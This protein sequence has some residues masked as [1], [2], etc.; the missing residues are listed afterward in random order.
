MRN[1]M[2]IADDDIGYRDQLSEL[3][4]DKFDI[5]TV[6]NGRE[7]M[8]YLVDHHKEIAIILVD[9]HM[10]IIDGRALLK[11]LKLKGVI[12]RIPVIMMT[13]DRDEAL[14]A[15]SFE[16]GATDMIY[17][18]FVPQV[19]A[20]R[21]NNLIALNRGRL[22]LE[23]MIR[24]QTV[25]IQEKN[26]ELKAFNSKLIEIMS[27]IVEFRNLESNSHIKKIKGISR[28]VAE[29][30]MRRYPNDYDLR[31]EKIEA[32]E[33]TAALHD[34]GMIA[35]PDSILLKP[36]KLTADEFEVIKS[37]TTLGCEILK[38]IEEL[39]DKEYITTSYNICRHHHERYDGKG[40]PD[41]LEGEAI[42]V[43]A[44]IVAL[45][46][47]YDSLI[48][49]RTYRDAFDMSKAYGMIMS[50]AAGSFSE[51]MLDCFAQSRTMIENFCKKF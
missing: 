49:D 24:Q 36:G 40:Y 31:P 23:E 30:I 18:P 47:A 12:K 32:I 13:T 26:N 14:I 19:I 48:S 16:N 29:T 21:V 35:I 50:G 11:V 6:G 7:A 22:Q 43:E 1:T 51:K 9:M 42:P 3:F 33:S 25:Q 37:H 27:S 20:A 41:H 45:A 46:D 34:I 39:Q 44:Q 10:P 5:A 15:E 2:L 38:Q 17:K 8:A 4:K 28:I